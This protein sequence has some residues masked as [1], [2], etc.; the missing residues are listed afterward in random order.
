[1]W[2][3]AISYTLLLQNGE[4]TDWRSHLRDFTYL[5]YTFSSLST[6]RGR[7]CVESTWFKLYTFENPFLLLVPVYH[8]LNAGVCL[9]ALLFAN[10]G[11]G[12]GRWYLWLIVLLV[13]DRTVVRWWLSCHLHTLF[14]RKF[15]SQAKSL[16]NSSVEELTLKSVKI[17]TAI[18]GWSTV[19]CQE[20]RKRQVWPGTHHLVR[21][22]RFERSKGIRQKGY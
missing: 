8:A 18:L 4:S 20:I 6:L 21:R 7:H 11:K 15:Y 16:F 14:A 13:S 17:R 19:W 3:K 5:L 22:V 9:L 1:M 10:S 12:K 2:Q